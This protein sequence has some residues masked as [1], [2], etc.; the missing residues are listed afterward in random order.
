MEVCCRSKIYLLKKKKVYYKNIFGSWNIVYLYI[1]QASSLGLATAISIEQ[2]PVSEL[3][4]LGLFIFK[5]KICV[6]FLLFV[7][8]FHFVYL[9]LLI[10][11]FRT[12]T[13]MGFK[14]PQLFKEKRPCFQTRR[15]IQGL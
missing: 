1:I 9:L 6:F 2:L 5:I 13:E 10:F 14:I 8:I 3:E 7:L 4:A 12:G 15:K 11:S